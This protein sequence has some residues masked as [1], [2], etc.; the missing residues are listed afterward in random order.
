MVVN[1]FISINHN[2]STESWGISKNIKM[3]PHS[4][5]HGWTS[6]NHPSSHKTCIMMP[7]KGGKVLLLKS[8]GGSLDLSTFFTYKF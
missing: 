6:D 5:L 1:S 4:S 8:L 7:F 2:Y 3:K